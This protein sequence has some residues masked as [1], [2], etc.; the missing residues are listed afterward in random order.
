MSFT[1]YIICTSIVYIGITTSAPIRR[2]RKHM[3]DALAHV[4][5]VS[6]HLY[7]AKSQLCDCGIA[8]LEYIEDAWWAAVRERFWWYVFR[9]W[10]VNDVAPGIP[11]QENPGKSR[12]WLNIKVLRLLKD[13]REA[14]N[15]EDR[16]PVK[17]LQQEL[18]ELGKHLSIP[19]HVASNVVVLNM[20][21]EQKTVLTRTMRKIVKSTGTKA[22]EK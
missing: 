5:N 13:I 16:V 10:A 6:L 1:L 17:C 8:P 9:H 18:S 4:D 14:Q 11:D 15:N 19:I 12:G 2:L 21:P 7:M 3:C 20:T 22:R